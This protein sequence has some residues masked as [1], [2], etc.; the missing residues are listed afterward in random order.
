MKMIFKK[1]A[2]Q[3]RS[4][5]KTIFENPLGRETL[6]GLQPKKGLVGKYQPE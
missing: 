1:L 2:S 5:P 3:R 4:F 6:Q